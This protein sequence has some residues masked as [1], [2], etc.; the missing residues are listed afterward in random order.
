MDSTEL[1]KGVYWVGYVDWNCRDFH[2]YVTDKGV[3]YNA[4]LV[5]DEKTALIDTVKAPFARQLM[6]NI[7]A[8]CPLGE[9]DYLVVNHGEPDHSGAFGALRAA[10]PQAKV[11]SSAKG[12]ET[13]GAYYGFPKEELTVV[14]TGDTLSLGQRNLRF[15]TTPMLHWPDSMATYLVEEKILFSND[16]FGQHLASSERF[17]DQLEWQTVFHEMKRYY[18]NILMPFGKVAQ[19]VL[20]GLRGIEL[21]MVAPSHGVILRNHIDETLAAYAQWSTGKT[22]PRV[23]VVYD[24]MWNSTAMMAEAVYQGALDAGAAA[25]FKRVRDNTLTDLATD[26]LDAG[27]I[28]VGTSTLNVGMLPSVSMYLDYI[29]GLKPPARLGLAFGSYGWRAAGVEQAAE[30]MRKMGIELVTDSPIA[31]WKPGDGVLAQCREAGRKLGERVLALK[32]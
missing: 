5:V 19:K 18:A 26:A 3:T 22:V 2:G 8:V 28:A 11:V 27:A 20:D 9:I 29:A 31:C 13:L 6:E 30:K 21:R 32:P 16:G 23:D 14:K 7:A 4:Y 25:T 1:A 17:D 24:T 15:I 10:A 12:A